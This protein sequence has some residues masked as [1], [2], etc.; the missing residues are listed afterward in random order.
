VENGLHQ[1][2]S[3][4]PVKR[5]AAAMWTMS[6]MSTIEYELHK[7]TFKHS[8]VFIT[9]VKKGLG[10]NRT[11]VNPVWEPPSYSR[12]PSNFNRNSLLTP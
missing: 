10:I 3:P 4:R 5:R 7:I 2:F 1:A 9:A 11:A 12:D 6:G 8:G